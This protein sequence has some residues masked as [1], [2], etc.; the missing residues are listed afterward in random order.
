MLYEVITPHADR[1]KWIEADITLARLGRAAYDITEWF[2]AQPWSDGK[3][4]M[5][6]NNFV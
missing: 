4:G 5:W 2:A 6:R 1:V 3:I